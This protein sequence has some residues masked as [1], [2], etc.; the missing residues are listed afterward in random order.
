MKFYGT[1]IALPFKNSVF[2]KEKYN[3]P[4]DSYLSCIYGIFRRLYRNTQP[5]KMSAIKLLAETHY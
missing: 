2:I 5:L 1:S 4:L 3:T